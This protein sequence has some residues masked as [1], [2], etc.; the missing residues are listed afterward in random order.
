MVHFS[1]MILLFLM[2][3]KTFSLLL[4]P[5]MTGCE[6]VA[7]V[8][9]CVKGWFEFT[10]HDY[11]KEKYKNLLENR[12]RK[13]P[14]P[15]GNKWVKE[16][17]VSLYH[18]ETNKSLK[19]IIKDLK[20]EDSGKY[21]CNHKDQDQKSRITKKIPLKLVFPGKKGCSGPTNQFVYITI[22][23]TITCDYPH[24]KHKSMLKFFCK[25]GTHTCENILS[26]SV[27]VNGT[28]ALNTVKA[29]FTV[30]ISNASVNHEGIYWCGVE[31]ADGQYRV[32]LRELNLIYKNLRRF[33]RSKTSGQNLTYWCSHKPHKTIFICKGE[34]ASV[35]QTLIN[36][37]KPENG[38]FSLKCITKG[39]T[40]ITISD[41]RTED[42]GT[43]WCG[44]ETEDK[45]SHVFFHTMMLTV[46]PTPP[47]PPTTAATKT[48]DRAGWNITSTPV[49]HQYNSVSSVTTA[50]IIGAAV[51][52]MV[53][54]IVL[55]LV[56]RRCS[57]LNNA[58]DG[59]AAQNKRE[60]NVYELQ[61]NLQQLENPLKTVYAS[62]DFP[63]TN[64]EMLHYSTIHFKNRTGGGTVVLGADSCE[65]STVK[66]TSQQPSKPADRFL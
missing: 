25:E 9:G 42:A 55:I 49:Q 26:T 39:N 40:T 63:R 21:T 37:T 51:L 15:R 58:G 23:T 6:S 44:A 52:L 56:Y 34:N 30:S 61:E 45:H 38:R 66:M 28:F 43:Y 2:N 65:Y 35:C 17:G 32:G 48:E 18:N 10:C 24:D 16:N 3:M 11:T 60:E 54:V 14:H 1:G 36:T 8:N 57:H 31:T 41:V 29:G 13:I 53:L 59:A 62:D 7:E 5:L 22:T 50:F 64:P 46:V 33:K 19:V 47:A 12:K 20:E 27:K 4:L